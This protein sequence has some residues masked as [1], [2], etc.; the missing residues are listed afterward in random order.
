MRSVCAASDCPVALTVAGSDSGGGAG[1]Q[2]DLRAFSRF[3]VHG[4]AAVT[5]VTAQTPGTVAAVVPV[6]T[7]MVAAQ[8]D[9]VFSAFA[10][11]AVKTGMLFTAQIIR[12]VAAAIPDTPVVP[13]V[14]DPV[15]VATSGRPLLQ[16]D[17][18]R[19][20]RDTLFP[21]ATLLTPNIPEAQTILGHSI[22]DSRA[23]V[24]AAAALAR[25]FGSA[26]LLKGGHACSDTAIDILWHNDRCWRLTAPFVQSQTSHG[27]GCALS[28]AVAARL[29]C[30]DQLLSAVREAKAYVLGLLTSCVR[31]GPDTW[32]MRGG[33][34]LP[35]GQ[36]TCEEVAAAAS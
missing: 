8:I 29:A 17:A 36:V 22:P 12:A 2:A 34:Q 14:V 32:V 30:G 35:A 11:G 7:T 24:E 31:T 3:G 33:R 10:V 21:R 5:A 20:L 9:A 18:V 6:P 1:L 13:L 23:A 27:T 19:T 25:R 16:Q 28:A 15:M 26:V 4:T